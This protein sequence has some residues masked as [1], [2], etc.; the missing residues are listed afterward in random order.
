MVSRVSVV[1][2]C[3]NGSKFL[4]ETLESALAQTHPPLEVIVVDDGSTDDS[5]A[6]A[7]SFDPPVRVIR[8]ENQGESVARNRGMDEAR[9]DWI[10]F[11]DADDLW[12][13]EKLAKQLSVIDDAIPPVV[14][15]YTDFYRFGIGEKVTNHARPEFH[16][17]PDYRVAMISEWSI[18]PSSALVAA[19]AAQGV[20]FPTNVREGE[21]MIFFLR[22]REFGR[23][24]RISTPLLGFRLSE[25]QQTQRQSHR[26]KSLKSRF[27]WLVNEAHYYTAAEIYAARCR[28]AEMLLREYARL[29]WSRSS[30]TLLRRCRRLYRSMKPDGED[31]PAIMRKPLVPNW[32]AIIKDRL[33]NSA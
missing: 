21:D 8:Q 2:P 9:G 14:C 22:L 32:L 3:Y 5:A 19:D 16:A 17:M 1:I 11:L 24:N 27:D 18:P 7:E 20:R 15:V 26:F 25:S 29:Y 23:F 10:A 13:P 33:S 31:L 28:L 30:N 4:R 12:K 6:I